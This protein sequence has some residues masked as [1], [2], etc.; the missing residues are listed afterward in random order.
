M[1]GLQDEEYREDPLIQQVFRH[2]N[3]PVTYLREQIVSDRKWYNS[4]Q[5]NDFSAP[6]GLDDNITSFHPVP[7]ARRVVCSLAL[8]RPMGNRR[9]TVHDRR[10]VELCYDEI[11]RIE[12]TALATA[13][14]ASP[15]DLSLR[16]R[17]VL[18]CLLE[19]D[20]EKQ[21]AARLGLSRDTVHEYV[22]RVYR[23]FRVRSRAEL[24]AY[25]VKRSGLILPGS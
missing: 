19:G 7:I 6:V 10:L 12:G 18:G 14:D 13:R 15:R 3:S 11:G 20:S 4:K 17:E 9:F 21:L 5:F 1:K 24:M 23:H 16:L 8:H 2:M 22:Q 25:F